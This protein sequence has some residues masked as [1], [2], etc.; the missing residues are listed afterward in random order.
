VSPP[1]SSW[2]YAP[3]KDWKAASDA[4][5]ALGVEW[6][7]AL[8][9]QHLRYLQAGVLVFGEAW[10]SLTA[11]AVTFG[12]T[13]DAGKPAVKRVRL[14]L[15][16]HAEWS[17]PDKLAAWNAWLSTRESEGHGEGTTGA[18]QGH[19]RGTVDPR[20][21]GTIGVEGHGEGTTGARQGHD[22]GNTRGS[23]PTTDHRLTDTEK[24]SAQPTPTPKPARAPLPP[25]EAV[26]DGGGTA[27][28]IANRWAA[29][30]RIEFP[31]T[32]MT[33]AADHLVGAFGPED[34]ETLS[35]WLVGSDDRD[36][37][38]KRRTRK[39]L[40]YLVTD[41]V[42]LLPFA[43]RFAEAAALAPA[44]AAWANMTGRPKWKSP[45][46]NNPPVNPKAPSKS[47]DWML[48]EDEAEHVRRWE[49]MYAAGGWAAVCDL[50]CGD[51]PWDRKERAAHKAR[52]LAAYSGKP[53]AVA[54]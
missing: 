29:F 45:A 46:R 39:G 42:G 23:T 44:E 6:P 12:W 34:A 4:L 47:G 14:L 27:T 48:A 8:A 49:A 15:S 52:W 19:D 32:A 40:R 37:V 24:Q 54:A 7:D 9:R 53:V 26:S 33:Q 21:N 22:R 41:G 18:R 20:P 31:D 36:A 43:R 3:R 5:T 16:K 35:L 30:W 13:T 25:L 10:P 50:P 2:D 1:R 51:E 17:D 28:R 11:L 38:A